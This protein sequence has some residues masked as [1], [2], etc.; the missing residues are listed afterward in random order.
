[1]SLR[2]LVPV[3]LAVVC[4]L[5]LAAPTRPAPVKSWKPATPAQ[6]PGAPA[7]PTAPRPPVVSYDGIPDTGQFL[8]D[9]ATL[10]RVEDRIIRV[11]DFVEAYFNSYGEDRPAPD[12]AGRVQ[13]LNTMINKNVLEI[14]AVA[15]NR[16]LGF[17]DRAVMREHTERVLSDVLFQRAVVDSSPVT[18]DEIQTV[19]HQYAY[20]TRMR[21]ILLRD[22][23][24]AERVRADLLAKRI[25]WSDAVRRH[26]VAADRDRD[27]DMGWANRIQYDPVLA[28][29]VYK[30]EPGEISPV[31]HDRDGYHVM[32]CAERRPV[33]APALDALRDVIRNQVRSYKVSVRGTALQDGLAREIGLVIDSANVA[34]AAS[35]FPT[36][37]VVSHQGSETIIDMSAAE[38][39]IGA[40]DTSRVLARHRH[41]QLS[42]GRF[43]AVYT[44]IN[45]ISRPPA[46]DFEALAGLVTSTVLEPYVAE[47]A[48]KRGLDRDSAAVS[49]IRR[50]LEQIRVEHMYQDSVQS[51]VWVRPADR[52]KYYEQ[53]KTEFVTIPRVSYA[54]FWRQT[55]AGA[56]SVAARLGAGEKAEAILRAD[57]AAGF[58]GGSIRELSASDHGAPFYKLLF[59]ELRPGKVA[60]DGPTRDSGYVAI[61]LITYDRSRQLAF[62][63]VVA[64]IDES[65]QN[66]QAEKLLKALIARH[67]AR[68]SI[69]A[70]PELLGR[71]RL[72]DPLL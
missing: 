15:A 55:R 52:R 41:G 69:E 39:Q 5:G 33:Q 44:S 1:M 3:V 13:F 46:S 19:Y 64:N 27:G 47:I 16:P 67:R 9:T 4:A 60:V 38:P 29:Q 40:E 50:R 10:A 59:E 25:G 63:E 43:L 62:D 42:L 70:H 22:R 23:A 2:G 58:S 28:A 37:D 65:L 11:R 8:P 56:D 12:E 20:Q 36:G 24:A 31:I 7:S 6:P 51:K 48:V 49:L 72:V 68:L 71:V 14:T 17:E 34:W 54:A 30:L 45:P 35:H 32:Q 57:S 18:E 66:I 21:H 61:Q 26:S 53:H